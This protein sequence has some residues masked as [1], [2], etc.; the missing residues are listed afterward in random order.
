MK[1]L[2]LAL[3]CLVSV[4]F[5]AS[6][7]PEVT[8]PEPSIAIMTGDN[9]VYDGQTI[10]LGTEYQIGF[11]AASNSETSKELSKFNFVITIADLDGNTTSTSDTTL[12]ISGTEYVFQQPLKFEMDRE[13]VAKVTVTATVTDVDG[14]VKS[15]SIGM[16]IN[17][18]AQTLE[19][20]DITWA[21]RG[22]NL[23]GDTEQEMAAVGLQWVA[24]DAY[25]ANI[26]PLNNC[27]LYVI[28]DDLETFE[29]IATD[30]DKAA[31]FTK[32]QE[33]A[34]PVEEYRNV[35][36]AITGDKTYNDILA[37]IDATGAAHLVLIGTANVQTGSFGVHT[38]ITGQVK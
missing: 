4:A 14:K 21:R 35:S 27:T 29:G 13:L 15:A 31:Y 33:L 36:V 23:Q 10:D 38:T 22:S 30:V 25:H 11:R 7:T 3:V 20:K 9:F 34:S 8:N 12:T 19:V 26:R 28:T 18:P 24:R 6:C 37:V 1:K 32:L 5:F 17:Q 2:A 16:S